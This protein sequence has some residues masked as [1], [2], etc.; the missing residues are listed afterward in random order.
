MY[1]VSTR[2]VNKVKISASRAVV[3]GPAPDGG[4]YVPCEFP[5]LHDFAGKPY[6]KI[7]FKVLRSYFTDFSAEELNEYIKSAYGYQL[8]V[9]VSGN[10]LEL[11]HGRTAAFKDVALQLYPYLLSSALK[12]NDV[13]KI[14]VV[15]VATSGDTGSAVIAGMANVPAMQAIVFYPDNG[16]SDVQKLQMT[17]QVGR[18]ISVFAVKGNFDDAQEAVKEIFEDTHFQAGFADDFIFTSANS[19][20]IGRLIPQIVYYFFAYSELAQS[21]RIREGDAINFAVPTGNFGNILAGYYAS[22][23][24]LP[25]NKLICATNS[26]NVLCDFIKTGT[27]DKK[28]D[29]NLTLSPS[30]DILLSSNLERLIYDI[31][32]CD[33]VNKAYGSLK[34]TGE[35]HI[36]TPISILDSEFVSDTETLHAIKTIY[37]TKKYIMDPHTAVGQFAYDK[38]KKRT[39]DETPTIIVSTASPYKFPETI[40]SA[41]GDDAP[42]NP[43]KSIRDL[44]GKPILHDE[45]ITIGDIRKVLGAVLAE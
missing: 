41:L 26:N 16:V 38:Y 39:G 3:N 12:K 7:A 4:L 14:A 1:Y 33:A 32:G 28:R 43:P 2:D 29:F 20:N 10:Y 40:K 9:K 23:M 11:F 31:G 36:D 24:G 17:T 27:Y 22:N 34:E 45:V 18:N 30:M 21:G 37:I 8:P 25:I 13:T 15:L 44:L 19:I 35:F 5:K 42:D 6:D